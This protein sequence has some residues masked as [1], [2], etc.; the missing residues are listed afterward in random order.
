MRHW[1]FLKS[2]GDMGTPRQGPRHSLGL[3]CALSDLQPYITKPWRTED[4][5]ACVGPSGGVVPPGL[6]AER[7]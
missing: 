4:R 7:P 1:H 5:I 3:M 2:T 6:G